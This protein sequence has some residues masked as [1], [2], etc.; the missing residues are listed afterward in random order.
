MTL[1]NVLSTHKLS[2][3]VRAFL[4]K[5]TAPHVVRHRW[6]LFTVA[7]LSMMA[8]L[9]LSICPGWGLA[10]AHPSG[11]VHHPGIPMDTLISKCANLTVHCR[12]IVVRRV[13]P[14]HMEL[15][16]FLRAGVHFMLP[17]IGIIVA[18]HRCTAFPLVMLV[19]ERVLFWVHLSERS[20]NL[21]L[22]VMILIVIF[23][24]SGGN[25]LKSTSACM[26][27]VIVE[28]VAGIGVLR[29]QRRLFARVSWHF[30]SLFWSLV[31]PFNLNYSLYLNASVAEWIRY[32]FIV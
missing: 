3:G 31:K 22:L 24:L 29:V 30:M 23:F 21:L 1:C 9:S 4:F 6:G 5:L 25:I 16:F 7:A 12:L 8:V 26:L 32:W 13:T 10:S 20:K 27:M 28:V 11:A 2:R 15:D 18:T 14:I 17:V 19:D